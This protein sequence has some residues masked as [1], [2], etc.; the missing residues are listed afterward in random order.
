MILELRQEV[1]SSLN[2]EYKTFEFHSSL[3]PRELI[4]CT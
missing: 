1:V 2:R 3:T 4:K